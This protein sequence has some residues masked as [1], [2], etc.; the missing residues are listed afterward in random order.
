MAWIG[1]AA[2]V[3]GSLI[4]SEMQSGAAEDAANAQGSATDAAVEEQ[5][6]QYDL[7]RSDLAP[8][9][10]TGRAALDQLSVLLGLRGGAQ[11]AGNR[12]YEDIRAE[13]LKERQDLYRDKYGAEMADANPADLTAALARIDQV[14]KERFDR[15]GKAL[16]GYGDL[17]KKFTLADFWDDP[18]T[19]ASYQQGLNQG[20]KAIS[21]MAGAAG[22]RNSGATLK[23][24]TRF[25]T[26]YTGNQA[27]GS[28]ARFV[29][30]QTNLYNRMA[31]VA[32]TGQIATTN[33]AQMGQNTANTIGG[34]LTAQGNARGAAAISGANTASGGIQN[35]ANTFG[36]WWN[37][38]AANSSNYGG[39]PGQFDLNN[40]QYGG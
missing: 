19:K 2:S 18:V 39:L 34:M 37:N 33:T 20:T 22:S 11:A 16:P 26:D 23:A 14:A 29:N 10:G 15:Q 36:N 24:L 25:G 27:A 31:G 38:G 28:Q 5:R 3:A 35:A 6:R 7:T 12:T 9:R 4:S 21:N 8:Y 17:T 1:V 30:D 32:G 40:R 13:L